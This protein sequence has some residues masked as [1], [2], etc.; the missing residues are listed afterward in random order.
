VAKVNSDENPN[1]TRTYSVMSLPTLLVF[2]QGEVVASIVGARPK[3]YLRQTLSA[4][5]QYPGHAGADA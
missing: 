4:H 2:R 3:N 1:T 5:A